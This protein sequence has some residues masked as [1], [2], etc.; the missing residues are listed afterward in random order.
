VLPISVNPNSG[1][2]RSIA[3]DEK[4]RA[5]PSIAHPQRIAGDAA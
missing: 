1:E 3:C 2:R 4:N 5:R